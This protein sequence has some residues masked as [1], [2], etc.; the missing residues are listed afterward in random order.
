MI[1]LMGFATIEHVA[2]FLGISWALIKNI[3][4]EYLRREYQIPDLETLRYIG[5]D[6][7]SIRKGHDY[8]TIFINLETGEI[9]HAVVRKKY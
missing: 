2:K 9:I 7:F 3:H 5:I 6:E 4:K 1:S 8:M